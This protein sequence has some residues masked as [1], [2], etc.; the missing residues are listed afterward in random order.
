MCTISVLQSH[1]EW[2]LDG[3]LQTV[4]H[5]ARV[6]VVNQHHPAAGYTSMSGL[7]ILHVISEVYIVY[8]YTALNIHALQQRCLCTE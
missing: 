3:E 2:E 8:A 6:R 5:S 1:A 4:H 7:T